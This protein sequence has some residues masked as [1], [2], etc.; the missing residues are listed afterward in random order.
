MNYD[1]FT[2]WSKTAREY[3]EQQFK[4]FLNAWERNERTVET[5]PKPDLKFWPDTNKFWFW[6]M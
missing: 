6:K 5:L 2:Q 3:S 1:V 4:Q